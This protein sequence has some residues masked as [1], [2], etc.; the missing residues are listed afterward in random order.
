MSVVL[1]GVRDRKREKKEEI[2]IA[3][4]L[5]NP[6]HTRILGQFPPK[7]SPKDSTYIVFFWGSFHPRPVP[8]TV[9][10]LCSYGTVSTQDQSQRQYI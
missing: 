2:K 5:L 7:T 8:K 1:F 4:S 6:F 3:A 9:H 10:I